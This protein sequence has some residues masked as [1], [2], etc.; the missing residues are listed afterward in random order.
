MKK[1]VIL[2]TTILT[3]SVFL[4]G[5]ASA[6]SGT[7]L[8]TPGLADP[9]APAIPLPEKG[10]PGVPPVDYGAAEAPVD[11]GAAEAPVDDGAA[12]APVDDGAAPVIPAAEDSLTGTQSA[13]VQTE[14]VAIPPT[15]LVDPGRVSNLYGVSVTD[16]NGVEIGFVDDAIVDLNSG[17][18]A[19]VIVAISSTDRADGQLAP[20]PFELLTWDKESSALKLK[21]D[22]QVV[23]DAP[24][25]EGGE[26]PD[27]QA[28][29]W[30]ADYHAYWEKYLSGGGM[31]EP[32]AP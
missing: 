26:Y 21:V 10:A 17:E 12:E 31:T 24:F 20:V 6:P 3:M 32:P 16:A 23:L 4:V 8:E 28:A 15:G 7:A 25:F 13:P 2:V 19:Y 22:A 9:N 29:E 11:D 18:I 1:L 30:E 5:C 27:T 14:A